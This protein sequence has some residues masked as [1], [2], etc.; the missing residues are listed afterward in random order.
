MRGSKRGNGHHSGR[1]LVYVWELPVRLFHWINALA[2]VVLFITGMY[3]G[4]P[5]SIGQGEAVHGFVMGKMRFWH[6]IFA[7]VFTINLLVRLYWF[8]RGNDYSK[9]KFWRRSFWQDFVATLKYYAFITKEHSVHVGHNALAQFMYIFF[10]WLAG[11][12]M[13]ITGFAMRGG[14]NPEG[15]WQTLFGWVVPGFG[16]EYQVRNFHHLLA[17]GFAVFLLGHLYMVI[18][19]DV[20]DDDGT[21]SSIING[22]KSELTQEGENNPEEV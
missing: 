15:I 18:R 1:E 19:Q 7:F 22:Y 10:V 11:G 17:W 14:N 16:G 13:I 2:I 3:I 5:L 6:S 20:L 9:L 8:W 21:V 12:F 4:N